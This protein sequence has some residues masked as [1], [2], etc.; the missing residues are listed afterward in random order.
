V[1]AIAALRKTTGG[2]GTNRALGG[3]FALAV[4]CI[5]P[6]AASAQWGGSFGLD[7]DYRLRG[8]SLTDGVPA[9]TGQLTY[10]HPS[11]IYVNLAGVARFG[12]HDPHFMGVIGNVGY[13]RRISGHVTLDAGL[14]RSQIRAT[15]RYER[16][17]R[18]TEIYGGAAVGPVVGRIYYSPDYRGHGVST[19][20]G[21]LEAGFEPAPEWRLSGHVGLMSYLD[22]T[23]YQSEGTK[24]PDWRVGA[25][26]QLGRLEIHTAVSGGG[27]RDVYYGYR[28]HSKPVVTAGASVSF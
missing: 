7:T 12:S 11:G 8:H 24:R 14:I 22:A 26:K 16:A 23:P 9:A 25:S 5:F 4:T 15:Y 3:A 1:T 13:A 27:A 6:A 19:I 17:Y 20:Y 2:R 10:D 21:E 18:Y 28:E